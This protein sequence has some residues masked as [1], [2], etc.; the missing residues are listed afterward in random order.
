MCVFGHILESTGQSASL[1]LELALKMFKDHVGIQFVVS[2]IES[3][4]T[5]GASVIG[6]RVI[7]CVG[8]REGVRRCCGNVDTSAG[9]IIVDTIER[10]CCIVDVDSID[11]TWQADSLGMSRI[12]IIY[13]K[14]A[15]V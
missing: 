2:S 14:R 7:A 8:T 1:L 6:R 5:V 11:D 15:I 13:H 10:V 3:E 4:N 12:G 9:S